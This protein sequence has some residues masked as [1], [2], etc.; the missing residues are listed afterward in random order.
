MN[1]FCKGLWLS[2]NGRRAF[3]VR[4]HAERGNEQNTM[5]ETPEEMKSF[6]DY[7]VERY[8]EH[9]AES[10]EEYLA[11]Y[12]Q[13]AVPF[14]ETD[15]PIE[16]LD[17]GAGT[18]IELEFIFA[19]APN[20]RVTAVDLSEAMLNK[21]IKKYEAYGSVFMKKD[22]VSNYLLDYFLYSIP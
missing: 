15:E 1:G 16:I 11:F 19:K 20:A 13:I 17:L 12:R 10:V 22:I 6:F 7:R 3:K 18:G 8:D 2:I 21:L 9:M 14:H 4:S 5:V